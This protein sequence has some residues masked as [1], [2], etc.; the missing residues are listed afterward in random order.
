LSEEKKIP[1][2]FLTQAEG[3][4]ALQLVGASITF[5]SVKFCRG[6]VG[7]QKTSHENLTALF[8]T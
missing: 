7:L 8:L 6:R 1:K 2:I 5:N 3:I 4:E